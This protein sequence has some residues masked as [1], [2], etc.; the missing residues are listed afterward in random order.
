MSLGQIK[1]YT[2]NFNLIIPRFDIATWH[3]YMESNFRSI[4]A[5]FFNMFG[6]NQYRGEW[7]NSTTYQVGDVLFIGD[8]ESQYS[9]RL[10]KVLVIHTTTANDSFDVYYAH[11]PINYDM[12]MDA[13]AAEQ[14]AKLARDWAI[15]TDGKVQGLDYSAKYYANLITPIS[16]E[17]VNVSNISN[18]IVNVSNNSTNIEN[19]NTISTNIIAVS[20]KI[21]E[22][23]TNSDN[24]SSIIINSNNIN[25]I[26]TTATNINS[27][28]N[29]SS[30]SNYVISVANNIQNVVDVAN[31]ETNITTNAT[32]IANIITNATNINNINTVSSNINTILAVD[33]NKNNINITATNINAINTNANN[34]SAIQNAYS[35]AQSAL[36]SKNKAQEWATSENIV[37][38]TDYSAKHYAEIASQY[39][40]PLRIGQIIQS[41]IP[42]TDAGLHLLDGSVVLGNGIYSE[43][44]S[45]IASLVNI[46]PDLFVTEANWQTSVLNYGVC[47]KFVYDSVN[48][49][50]RLPKITGFIESTVN[51]TEVDDLVEAGLPEIFT[52]ST[53]YWIG[54]S[55]SG[56]P[57][58]SSGTGSEPGGYVRNSIQLNTT[59]Q[60]SIYGN[61]TT[62]QPQSIK[63]LYYVVIATSIKTDIQIDIDDIVA[64]LN[65]LTNQITNISSTLS[66]KAN[67]NSVVHLTGN[68]T[69][70]DVKTFSNSPVIP[71]PAVS[72]NTTVPATTAYV[73]N[74]FMLVSA[75]PAS[76]DADTYYFI[77]E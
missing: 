29:V 21:N 76:P 55:G 62:V 47:G 16:A 3:D 28:N 33:S 25:D 67:D 40:N 50:V 17:I 63:V 53:T 26:N 14:A 51:V 57:D 72:S 52:S 65:A 38:N 35:N 8:P 12:F 49:T 75:L 74:K 36:N 44:V 1:D 59:E 58:G 24:I 22:I 46:Y 41:T 27:I 42:L 6:I 71:T 39:E 7:Q 11:N 19:V 60:N 77:P 43:F 64:D 10:V 2:P 32:N 73:N 56:Y 34:I 15:K 23:I 61:S 20:N 13:A 5:L 54:R 37:D 70:S 66:T 45:Y 4:D 69:I 31:N 18:E 48:N 30:I 68:E 9:G